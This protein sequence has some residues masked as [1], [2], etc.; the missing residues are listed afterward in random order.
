[1]FNRQPFNRGMFN[2]SI[3]SNSV[4]LYGDADIVIGGE[5]DAMGAAR[6]FMGDADI[7]IGATGYINYSA[8][9]YG[10]ATLLFGSD[11]GMTRARPLEGNADIVLSTMGGI[12]R[13][14]HLQGD[15][16]IALT[17]TGEGF[18][19]F[20]YEVISLTRPGFLFGVGDELVIDMENMTVT[21]NGQNVMKHLDRESEFFS[22]NP[23]NNE[24]TF[25]STETGG[26]VDIRILWKDAWI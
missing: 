8:N 5:A 11:G 3:N 4:L 9:F 18:N 17:G 26:R 1:M 23:G 16:V 20:R 6:G 13:A 12:V 14:R 15:A 24:I 25:E 2:R 10:D 7:S 19:T 21:L 22:L